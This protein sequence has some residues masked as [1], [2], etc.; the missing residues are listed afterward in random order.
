MSEG[1]GDEGL[2]QLGLDLGAFPLVSIWM[3]ELFTYFP[4]LATPPPTHMLQVSLTTHLFLFLFSD[5]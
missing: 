3:R 1:A 4:S 5:G 2:C